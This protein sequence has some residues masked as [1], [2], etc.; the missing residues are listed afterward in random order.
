MKNIFFT[1]FFIG[2]FI[3]SACAQA[4]A[5]RPAVQNDKFDQRLG[6]LLSFTVPLIGVKELADKK[7]EYVILDTREQEEYTLSHIEGAQH[8]GYGQLN[9]TVLSDLDKDTPIVLYCSV[10]YRSEKIG[11]RLKKKGFTN[12]YNLYGSIFEWVNQGQPV[13]DNLCK[14]FREHRQ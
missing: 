6:S 5:V 9:Q 2:I 7:E 1:P 3:L 8:L 4:P 14:Q 11:E 12:V 10:G 13:V